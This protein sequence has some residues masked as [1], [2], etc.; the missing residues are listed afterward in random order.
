MGDLAKQFGQGVKARRKARG[1]TQAQLA[2][3][4]STSEEWIRRIERGAGAPSFDVIEALAEAMR[5]SA[6]DLFTPLSDRAR[7]ASKL[8]ALLAT[9]PEPDLKWIEGLIRA[10]LTRPPA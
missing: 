10:A 1:M 3:A 2:E 7:Q 6:A 8:D 5:C 4:T 9:V